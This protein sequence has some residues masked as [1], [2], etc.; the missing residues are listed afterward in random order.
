MRNLTGNHYIPE[1]SRA[2]SARQICDALTRYSLHLCSEAH[3]M[4]TRGPLTQGHVT[5][6]D[7]AAAIDFTLKSS[8]FDRWSEAKA[9]FCCASNHPKFELHATYPCLSLNLSNMGSLWL[10]TVV[11]SAVTLLAVFQ[12]LRS[13]APVVFYATR[14]ALAPHR[15]AVKMRPRHRGIPSTR[16]LCTPRN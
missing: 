1:S 14:S 9:W 6:H 15:L 8:S 12:T 5:A 2:F 4:R 10:S 16:K 11:L 7:E 3:H 13:A